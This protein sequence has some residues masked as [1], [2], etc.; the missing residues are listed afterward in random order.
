MAGFAPRSVD[1]IVQF[2]GWGQVLLTR[3]A[4]ISQVL[5]SLKASI[6]KIEQVLHIIQAVGISPFDDRYCLP[7][8]LLLL[9]WM[10]SWYI[11]PGW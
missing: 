10:T 9:D 6:S 11:L 3:M 1:G 2:D 4:G 5:L 7:E 8:L